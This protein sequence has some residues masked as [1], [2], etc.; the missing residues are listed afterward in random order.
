MTYNVQVAIV[1]KHEMGVHHPTHL[2]PDTWFAVVTDVYNRELDRA[3]KST[4][5]RTTFNGNA[6]NGTS[7]TVFIQHY[8]I[9]FTAIINLAELQI[10]LNHRLRCVHCLGTIVVTTVD[11]RGL[12]SRLTMTC[13]SCSVDELWDSDEGRLTFPQ[14]INRPRST[15]AISARMVFAMVSAGLGMTACNT[16]LRTLNIKVIAH[17]PDQTLASI[18]A[19]LV[20]NLRRHFN[21]LRER[22]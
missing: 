18:A 5:Q 1:V 15:S 4:K 16:I 17:F 21:Q 14:K 13:T 3:L 8:D 20:C 22:H 11:A 2:L 6:G 7:K 9:Y 12:S 10:L 19:F